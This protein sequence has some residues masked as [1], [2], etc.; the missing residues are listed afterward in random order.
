MTKKISKKE[1]ISR[2]ENSELI[3]MA[4]DFK[5]K[6]PSSKKRDELIEALMDN[7]KK[8]TANELEEKIENYKQKPETAKAKP[9]PRT[10]KTEPKLETTKILGVITNYRLGLHNQ[11]NKEL[12]IRMPNINSDREASKYIGH[13][14]IWQSEGGSKIV[15]K[16]L[17]VH[18]KNGIMRA[19]FRRSL[20]GQAIGTNVEII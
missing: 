18:G 1:I 6:S 8:V 15:G 16:I 13:K 9:K 12:L 5:I 4:K 14:T 11:R 3:L 17:G 20:P 19:R 7:L 2:L 10:I